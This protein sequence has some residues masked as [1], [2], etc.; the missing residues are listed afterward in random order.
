MSNYELPFKKNKSAQ[1]PDG[2]RY[3]QEEASLALDKSKL[4]DTRWKKLS[5]KFASQNLDQ[6]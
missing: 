6:K 2:Q 1:P 4:K 5:M 3:G